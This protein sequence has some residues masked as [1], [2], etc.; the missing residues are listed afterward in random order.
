M[1]LHHWPKAT[2]V[3]PRAFSSSHH[4]TFRW[5]QEAWLTSDLK[6]PRPYIIVNRAKQTRVKFSEQKEYMSGV[7]IYTQNRVDVH[8]RELVWSDGIVWLIPNSYLLIVDLLVHSLANSTQTCASFD[9]LN[10]DISPQIL[11]F[12]P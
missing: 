11:P 4:T 6:H 2:S 5:A 8:L 10:S 7:C 12:S 9:N 3:L 1:G